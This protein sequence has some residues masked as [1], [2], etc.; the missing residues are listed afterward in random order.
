M[1]G[2]RSRRSRVTRSASSIALRRP[3]ARKPVTLACFSSDKVVQRAARRRA[4]T[5]WDIAKGHLEVDVI[6]ASLWG[7]KTSIWGVHVGW[8]VTFPFVLV[9]PMSQKGLK[10][11]WMSHMGHRVHP[12]N[13]RVAGFNA[14][15]AARLAAR[16]YP[17]VQ[18]TSSHYYL[19][20]SGLQ[21]F[22]AS[23]PK[24]RRR[25]ELR[26][27]KYIFSLRQKRVRRAA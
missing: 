21:I 20:A 27:G 15:D 4:A 22:F 23:R 6:K 9:G 3:V 11:L 7:P 25:Q 17:L 1:F 14:S 24:C 16:I 19:Q 5:T 2:R 26:T 8:G 13:Q 18:Y 10:C 12:W